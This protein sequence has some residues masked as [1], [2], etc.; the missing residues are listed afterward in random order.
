MKTSPEKEMKATID[1]VLG[2]LLYLTLE[3]HGMAT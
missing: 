3:D 1:Y 2:L